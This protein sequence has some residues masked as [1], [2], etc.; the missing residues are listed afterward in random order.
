MNEMS[1]NELTS[2]SMAECDWREECAHYP[3]RQ[4]KSGTHQPSD[5]D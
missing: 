3:E 4:E 5:V 2:E 1:C